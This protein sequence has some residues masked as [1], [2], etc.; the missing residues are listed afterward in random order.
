MPT[1]RGERSQAPPRNG[2]QTE[3]MKT[4]NFG[5][6]FCV[7]NTNC[8]S[9][10]GRFKNLND[11]NRNTVG[12]DLQCTG[13]N[14]VVQVKTKCL[15]PNGKCPLTQTRK[16]SWDELRVAST[17]TLRRTL[18]VYYKQIRY[19]CVIYKNTPRGKEVQ[20][21]AITELLSVKNICRGEKAI[22]AKDTKWIC[23]K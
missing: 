8:Q 16:S 4:G 14:Q 10:G 6:Q 13:C 3:R 21:I 17:S 18:T 23:Y 12:V 2:R 11:E 7:E 22:V 5:E 15:K 20:Y 19:Y 9:C 1:K